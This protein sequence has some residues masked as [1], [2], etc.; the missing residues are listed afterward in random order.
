[1]ID[2]ILNCA[3]FQFEC[4]KYLEAKEYLYFYRLLVRHYFTFQHTYMC[5]IL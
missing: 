4:G 3:K 2:V 5:Y 1:M